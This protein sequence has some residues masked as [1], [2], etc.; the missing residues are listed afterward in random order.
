MNDK[1]NCLNEAV[2]LLTQGTS[3]KLLS[4][5]TA[6]ALGK[7]ESALNILTRNNITNPPWPHIIKYR[8]AHLLMRNPQSEDDLLRADELLN[9][10]TKSKSLGLLPRIYRVAV[11]HR[12]GKTG[13]MIKPVFESLLE[14]LNEEIRQYESDDN[15]QT[16]TSI[17]S[18]WFNM[19]ELATYF[20]GYPYDGL[21]GKGHKTG[22]GE[23]IAPIASL[24][25]LISNHQNL[26]ELG[27]FYDLQ[28]KL[29]QWHLFG[30]P[31]GLVTTSYPG[32]MVLE[33][34]EYRMNN[35]EIKPPCVAFCISHDRSFN[36][37]N[38]NLTKNKNGD[39]YFWIDLEEKSNQIIYLTAATF[40]KENIDKK[41]FL[42]DIFSINTKT[43]ATNIRKLKSRCGES[44]YEWINPMGSN[45][46]LV[47]E[48][49]FVNSTTGKKFLPKLNPNISCLGAV[50]HDVLLNPTILDDGR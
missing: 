22:Y 32:E 33:E 11:M 6:K 26:K 41:D 1:N 9:D 25:H 21:E 45:R 42:N 37:W 17:Q 29:G 28:R 43:A 20:T 14:Q 40:F 49:V 3:W 30:S 12:L 44:V 48:E 16:G 2:E 24:K 23:E 4:G 50:D 35:G 18:S 8:I 39:G 15:Y 46:Y 47:N 5:G 31:E 27:P 7:L 19:L 34:M 36:R 13:K 38:F 10:A